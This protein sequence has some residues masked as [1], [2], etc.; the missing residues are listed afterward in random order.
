MTSGVYYILNIINGKRY[1][2]SSVNIKQRWRAHL[3]ELRNGIHCNSHLQRAFDKYGEAVFVFEILENTE[4]TKCVQ[5]EQYYLDLLLP[6]YNLSS[7][8][9]SLLGYKHTFETRR[10]MSTAKKGKILSKEHRRK[11]SEAL[12]GRKKLPFSEEHRKNISKARRG[13]HLSDETRAKISVALQGRKRGPLSEEHRRKIS[14]AH[15]GKH[16]SE[17]TKQKMSAA[18]SGDRNS[19][20][21]KR[22]SAETR[23]K[24]SRAN[25][26]ERHPMY[27]KHPSD[28]TRARLSAA[29]KG[30]RHPLYGKHP[31]EE[32][33][34]KMSEA[35]K[36][37][38]ARRRQAANNILKT[39]LKE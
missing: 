33:R 6:E 8:A 20:Y 10:K 22:H 21:G 38:W 30:K 13:R 28:E 36:R 4:R 23:A 16:H 39:T 27:G 2:G 19:F 32:T 9:G 34:R 15:K 37:I 29:K 1:I 35:H 25:T 11:L 24:I 7:M 14:E 17:E 3:R 31:S 5:R 26:G 18:K 12:R